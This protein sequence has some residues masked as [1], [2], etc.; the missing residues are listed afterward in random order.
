MDQGQMVRDLIYGEIQLT[1]IASAVQVALTAA[2][3]QL[4]KS[5]QKPLRFLDLGSGS[6]RAVMIVAALGLFDCSSGIEVRR[7]HNGVLVV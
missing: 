5:D 6:G 1:G 2:L 3:R 4:P 7:A